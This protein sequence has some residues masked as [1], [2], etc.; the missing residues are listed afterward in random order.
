MKKIIE[1]IIKLFKRKKE[2][3]IPELIDLLICLYTINELTDS[4]AK[5]LD[6]W[7]DSEPGNTKHF[8]NKSIEYKK[9]LSEA[10][11]ELKT[12]KRIFAI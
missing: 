6:T 12:I 1:L 9:K 2:R 8:Y 5:I 7:C 4:E 10:K 3:T 11:K